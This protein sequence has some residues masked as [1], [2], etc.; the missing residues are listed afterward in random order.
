MNFLFYNHSIMRKVLTSIFIIISLLS[1]NY[2]IAKADI[3][4]TSKVLGC[5]SIMRLA[6]DYPN[7]DKVF[8][9]AANVLVAN[10]YATAQIAA[11][12]A[13]EAIYLTHE[14]VLTRAVNIDNDTSGVDIAKQS[15]TYSGCERAI[16]DFL[17]KN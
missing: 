2:A 9:K 8:S 6:K 14:A 17:L 11:I 1:C 10:G 7:A 5:T 12:A 4:T 15:L 13:N 16:S 3:V